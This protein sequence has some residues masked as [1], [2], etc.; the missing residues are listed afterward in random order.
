MPTPSEIR[1]NLLPTTPLDG[2]EVMH[3]EQAG[4]STGVTVDEIGERVKLTIPVVIPVFVPGVPSASDL[5]FRYKIA[6]G[7]TIEATA[8]DSLAEAEVASTGT[9]SF[10]LQ[11]NGVSF[12][13]VAFA[14]SDT[15]AYTV[16]FDAVFAPGDVLSVVAP[17][18]PDATLADIGLT[19]VGTY[20]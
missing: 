14:T 19:L 4:S 18:T 2:T 7:F 6:F 3:A 20:L 11:K 15:G 5:V 16:S 9:V 8:P 13:T 17:A 1:F 12:G 10:D